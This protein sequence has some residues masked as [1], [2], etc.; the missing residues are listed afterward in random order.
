MNSKKKYM[1]SM[2][3][4]GYLSISKKTPIY[5][6]TPTKNVSQNNVL[7]NNYSSKEMDYISLNSGYNLLSKVMTKNK[8]KGVLDITSPGNKDVFID[9]DSERS[10][11][12][13]SKKIEKNNLKK[14]KKNGCAKLVIEKVES[15]LPRENTEY[16]K[17]TNKAKPSDKIIKTV[18]SKKTFVDK[19]SNRYD[20]SL[21]ENSK[22]CQR[23]YKNHNIL[24][25]SQQFFP[26]YKQPYQFYK[27]NA[28]NDPSKKKYQNSSSN[29]ILRNINNNLYKSCNNF[30]EPGYSIKTQTGFN[31]IG[32]NKDTSIMSKSPMYLRT[33]NE[34]TPRDNSPIN[35]KSNNLFETESNAPFS[36]NQESTIPK[37]DTKI[38]YINSDNKNS[39]NNIRYYRDTN[40]EPQIY[41]LYESYKSLMKLNTFNKIPRNNKS[42]SKIINSYPGYKEKLIKLQAYWRGSYVR[43]LMKFYWTLTRFKDK[44]YKVFQNYKFDY[45]KDFI[46]ILKNNQSSR[47]KNITTGRVAINQR[48]KALNNKKKNESK[49]QENRRLEDFKKLLSQKEEDYY[50]LLKN[51]NSLVEKCTKLEQIINQNSDN[52]K[53]GNKIIDLNELSLE[54][55]NN[56]ENKNNN[57]I[58][59]FDII[60][61]EQ[62]DIF[63]IIQKNIKNT[64]PDSEIINNNKEDINTN[65][66][67]SLNN[68]YEDYLEHFKSN[69]N[70]VNT[71]QILIEKNSKNIN[72]NP[73]EISNPLI[74]IN[75]ENIT[76][77]MIERKSKEI[78]DKDQDK[79]NYE[80]INNVKNYQ[81]RNIVICENDRFSLIKVSISN[82]INKDKDEVK[83]RN[84]DLEI[85]KKDDILLEETNK[86][87][88]KKYKIELIIVNNDNL[89]I[90]GRKKD[91]CDKITE[92]TDELNK[93]EP[94]NHYELIFEGIINLNDDITNKNKTDTENKDENIKDKTKQEITNLENETNKES[95][96]N[97]NN[98]EIHKN[99]NF[100]LNNEI[101]KGI[102][103]EINTLEF[104][105]SK[106][107]KNKGNNIFIN[108]ENKLEVLYNKDTIFTEK[109]KK[110]MMKIILPIR[111]K[112]TLR[113]FAHRNIFP[114]L[115][116]NLKNI[117]F[118]SHLN[119]VDNDINNDSKKEAIDK[120]KNNVKS[121]FYKEY[122]DN[123]M[124]KKEI[125]HILNHYVI[126]K[127]NKLL[128]E[129]CKDLICNK[130]KILERLKK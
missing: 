54:N 114:L 1:K 32:L 21:K 124:K 106:V 66:Y 71:E 31:Q 112:S 65:I 17:F 75:K 126:Y 117:A 84:I 49:E 20:T 77:F 104:K 42:N 94:N 95:D 72:K 30:F 52:N 98:N 48:L 83:K 26:N 50:N 55:N 36:Y 108:Y 40:E 22:T 87:K 92:I 90:K 68:N 29:N 122:Y 91:K 57:F 130:D 19:N 41:T 99:I 88:D 23:V 15:Q 102:G 6:K 100:N 5:K 8:Y 45:F 123:Q 101:E 111:L 73:L 47:K 125:R 86:N 46:D 128:Y 16:Y 116:N 113:E 2:N 18:F 118:T 96:V 3:T 67:P 129:L 97:I 9:S 11:A 53:K 63:Y 79:V 69:L 70:K 27:E 61:P 56:I 74:N 105:R 76:Q 38:Y 13:L 59:K 82:D 85:E 107:K 33:L 81:E 120:I 12:K 119:K 80:V 39:L 121:K 34:I 25:Q 4:V 7:T 58:K 51:Y 115:I 44:I 127:W 43:E 10:N 60:E 37:N 24:A 28:Y 109:A 103:M 89:F 62:K 64:I 14:P 110:N 93:I 78:I 35:F